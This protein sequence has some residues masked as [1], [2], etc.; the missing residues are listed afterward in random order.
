[1]LAALSH[2]LDARQQCAGDEQVDAGVAIAARL[3]AGELARQLERD[4][5]DR[6]DGVHDR[7]AH[8]RVRRQMLGGVLPQGGRERL[9]VPGRDGQ[10][11]RGAVAAEALQVRA[12]GRE[13][14]VQVVI[15]HGAAAALAAPAVQRDQD[16]RAAVP[17]DQARCD[18]ADHALVPALARGHEDAIAALERSAAGDLGCRRTQDRILHLLTFAI[19]RLDLL[20]QGPGL[21]ERRREQEVE[22]EPRIAEPA[23]GVDARREPESEVGPA[24]ARGVDA[25]ARHE[26]AQ[27]GAVGLGEAA[28][29]APDER[30]VLIRQWDDIGDR[31]QRHEVAEPVERG[32]QL[33]R[34]GAVPA[35]PE[36]QRELEHDAR[37]AQVGERIR[38][39]GRRA[40]GH[41]GRI[42]EHVAGSVVVGHDDVERELTRAGD[43]FGRRDAAVHGDQQSGAARCKRLDGLDRDAVAV[44]EAARQ[45]CLDLPA[46]KSQHLDR[47]RGGTDA[48]DVVVAVYDDRTAC[49]DRALDQRAGLL[50][51]AQ[52]EGVV[53]RAV[54]VE[55]C[56]RDVRVAQPAAYE[57]LGRHALEAQSVGRGD[58]PVRGSSEGS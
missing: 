27:A 49:G 29:A 40:R 22:R 2:A 28:Q 57:H 43:G 46:E 11:G 3:E 53:Q 13:A 12:R 20:G 6:D 47:E 33:R 5:S 1:M 35:R 14:R 54:A 58:A 52:P 51:V 34:V 8:A 56:P 19:A 26:R 50:D 17:L 30:A 44:L 24:H 42:G 7:G 32:R 38:R 31:R 55:E 41:D 25:G 15:R 10:A 21:G 23:G 36:R 37:T 39:P 9:D 48:V 4:L 16:D 45:E 18:D